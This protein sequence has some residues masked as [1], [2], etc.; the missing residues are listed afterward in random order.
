MNSKNHLS[1]HAEKATGIGDPQCFKGEAPSAKFKEGDRVRVRDLPD[2]F[3][4]R[5]QVYT[6]GA[7][8]VVT[9]LVYES[10]A[11]EDEAWDNTDNVMWFYSVVFSMKE[12]WPEYQDS[13]TDDTLETEL[14]E[15]WLEKA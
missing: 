7:E 13:Y 6:R 3:Y 12:L 15:F 10:P 9:K 4:T 2:I 8:G 5:C 14:P 1:H 11:A